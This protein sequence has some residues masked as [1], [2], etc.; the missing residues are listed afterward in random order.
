[1]FGSGVDIDDCSVHLERNMKLKF[2]GAGKQKK[3]QKQTKKTKQMHDDDEG[4][5]ESDDVC[6]SLWDTFRNDFNR[7]KGLPTLALVVLAC[8]LFV[9]KWGEMADAKQ[10]VLYFETFCFVFRWTRAQVGAGNGSDNN[11]LEG[12]N[13]ATKESQRWQRKRLSSFGPDL[14]ART[15]EQSCNDDGFNKTYNPRIWC[16][17]TFNTIESW[18]TK[19]Y[20]SCAVPVY[21]HDELVGFALPSAKLTARIAQYPQHRRSAALEAKASAFVDVILASTLL[22]N[23]PATSTA[24][25]APLDAL[26]D[27][28]QVEFADV[29]ADK[30]LDHLFTFVDSFYFLRPAQYN[31]TLTDTLWSMLGTD[32]HK[33]GESELMCCSCGDYMH[34]LCCAHVIA[35]HMHKG[36]V[37]RPGALK[38][39]K[40]VAGGKKAR[41]GSVRGAMPLSLATK[42]PRGAA[43]SKEY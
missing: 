30:Q 6:G 34:Y 37:H 4:D 2:R 36:Q 39:I 3:K 13:R 1:M 7:I 21:I 18:A 22:E 16:N 17:A 31:D 32:E 29:P 26:H 24:T 27:T 38:Q 35:W 15:R 5:D 42:I 40:R 28:L 19:N 8:H 33:Q 14:L 20:M 12:T 9:L 23:S 10:A 11:P 41:G 25:G 43:L